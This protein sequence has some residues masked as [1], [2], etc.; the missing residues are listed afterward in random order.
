MQEYVLYYVTD[1]FFEGISVDHCSLYQKK[2]YG[3]YVSIFNK[4]W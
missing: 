1:F 3:A 2:Y 4:V